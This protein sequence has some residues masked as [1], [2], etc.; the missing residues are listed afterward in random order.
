M[1]PAY[2]GAQARMMTAQSGQE[3]AQAYVQSVK[4]RAANMVKNWDLKGAALDEKKRHSLVD[5]AQAE[6]N[7]AGRNY[8]SLHRDATTEDVAA[9]MSGTR[10]Q[11]ANEAAARDPSVKSWLF[12]ALGIDVPQ[13]QSAPSPEFRPTPKAGVPTAAPAKPTPKPK[14]GTQF[15]YDKQGNRVAEP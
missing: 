14:A 4:D 13:V 8:R 7:E 11:I 15:H 2:M 12:N 1:G 3:R 6:A 5:E 9:V 10:T